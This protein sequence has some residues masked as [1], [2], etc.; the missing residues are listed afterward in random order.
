[1]LSAKSKL[2]KEI[3]KSK[4]KINKKKKGKNLKAISILQCKKNQLNFIFIWSFL[5]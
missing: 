2:F 5:F 4:K 1:M 3:E